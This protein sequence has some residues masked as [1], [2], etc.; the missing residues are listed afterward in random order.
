MTRPI[1]EGE[2][3]APPLRAAPFGR[4]AGRR[5]SYQA[6]KKELLVRLQRVSGQ[7][8]GIAKMVD[9]ERY[10]PEVLVQIR[11]VTAALDQIGYLLLRDHLSHCVADGIRRGEGDAYLDEVI[12]VVR[13]Y[14]RH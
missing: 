13:G 4:V 9:E 10:C 12:E 14:G 7:V 8:G 5:G 2:A 3:G 1:K 11:S 6:S